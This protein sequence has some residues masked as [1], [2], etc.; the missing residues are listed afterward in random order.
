MIE[1]NTSS[2]QFSIIITERPPLPLSGV[3]GWRAEADGPWVYRRDWPERTSAASD[4]IGTVTTTCQVVTR[5]TYMLCI[6]QNVSDKTC[7]VETHV[8]DT[9]RFQCR[10]QRDYIF[11]CSQHSALIEY[12]YL[13]FFFNALI[14][15]NIVGSCTMN[16]W[17]LYRT[18][19]LS[20][21]W[22]CN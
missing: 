1:L 19:K 8:S 22:S 12:G 17:D 18:N 3:H 13:R 20:T 6:W 10:V 5:R 7:P 4:G 16:I 9:I 21:H 15:W 11:F 14:S 2:E